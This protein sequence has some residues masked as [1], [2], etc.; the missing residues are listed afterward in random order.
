MV[1]E[2]GKNTLS[3]SLFR[4]LE[5]NSSKHNFFTF[6]Q[7]KNVQLYFSFY[8]QKYQFLSPPKTTSSHHKSRYQQ[9]MYQN[10]DGY[11]ELECLVTCFSS[12]GKRVW[13]FCLMWWLSV[14]RLQMSRLM[15]KPTKWMCAQRRLSLAWAST[16]SNQNLRCVLSGYLS[17]QAFFMRSEDSDQTG[18]I[19][20]LIWVF[21]GRTVI[22]FVLTWGGSNCLLSPSCC[23][24]EC[25]FVIFSP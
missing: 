12:Q 10:V 13:V 16:Y 20:R 23:L 9:T 17:T 6:V 2:F 3:T 5:H 8:T 7:T 15:S 25:C 18:R 11:S 22:L 4:I 19:P 21:A 1:H 24:T 14:C